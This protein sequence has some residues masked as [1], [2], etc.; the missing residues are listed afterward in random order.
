MGQMICERWKRHPSTV[1]LGLL[2]VLTGEL[3]PSPEMGS[4]DREAEGA[5]EAGAALPNP[6]PLQQSFLPDQGQTETETERGADAAP[7]P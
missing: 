3:T 5:G 6:D 4:E 1:Y 2:S 7:R